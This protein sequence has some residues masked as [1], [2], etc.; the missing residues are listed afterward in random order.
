MSAQPVTFSEPTGREKR[1]YERVPIPLSANITVKDFIGNEVGLICE[2]SRGGMQIQLKDTPLCPGETYA[3]T[4]D[5]PIDGVTLNVGV[6]V[7]HTD[8]M[9]VGCQF[10]H[11]DEDSAI[12]IG[13]IIGRYYVFA[14]VL[15]VPA[16]PTATV[17][18][19]SL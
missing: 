10:L 5:D 16:E 9:R 11:L 2:L 6:Q 7:R 18:F 13:T 19:F 12:Q 8:F 1:K 14:P 15:S 3:L 17:T 4:I